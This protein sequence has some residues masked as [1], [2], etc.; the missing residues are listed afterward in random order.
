MEGQVTAAWSL[1][2][3]CELKPDYSPLIS[4]SQHGF[5]HVIVDKSGDFTVKNYTII[6]GKLH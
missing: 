4:N 1:G 6:K 2:C 3:L 5:A